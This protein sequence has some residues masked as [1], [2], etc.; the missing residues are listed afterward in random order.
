MV[1]QILTY[2]AA[3]QEKYLRLITEHI[4]ISF[5]AVGWAVV[6]GFLLSY[7]G[8]HYKPIGKI[9]SVGLSIFRMIP[10]LAIL[11]LC[12]PYIGVGTTPAV[13]ALIILAIPP[14]YINTVLA[15]EQVPAYY[16]EVGQGIGF[17][18]WHI[19]WKVELPLAIPTILSGIRIA[20]I[21][22]IASATIASYI[23][24]GGIG[25]II[26]TGLNLYRMDLL[27][28]GGI[29]VAILAMSA[30]GLLYLIERRLTFYQRK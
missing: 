25:S 2:I 9:L 28:L 30:D 19:F 15:F 12:I 7:I 18:R 27:I 22:V 8:Y 17:T 5:I 29:T 16:N 6:I 14:I 20:V 23:G 24:A 1:Q 10:S 3:N 4:H 26:L 21:E 11:I 13:I